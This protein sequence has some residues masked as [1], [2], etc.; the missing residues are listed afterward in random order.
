MRMN[1]YIEMKIRLTYLVQNR[2]LYHENIE[3]N[4]FINAGLHFSKYI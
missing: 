3:I 2:K 4:I 1:E